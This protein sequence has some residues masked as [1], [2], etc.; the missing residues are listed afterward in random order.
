MGRGGEGNGERGEMGRGGKGNG[1]GKGRGGRGVR[2]APHFV[3]A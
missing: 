2:R 1:E 3:L